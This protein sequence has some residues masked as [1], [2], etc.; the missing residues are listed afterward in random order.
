MGTTAWD[1]V[2]L[3]TIT[4]VDLLKVDTESTVTIPKI[5]ISG[6]DILIGNKPVAI[7]DIEATTHSSKEFIKLI[8][9]AL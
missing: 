4:V 8:K 7:A 6:G 5:Q 3:V 2:D 9:A 1:I